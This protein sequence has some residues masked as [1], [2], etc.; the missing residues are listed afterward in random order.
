MNASQLIAKIGDPAFSATL[1]L[2]YG[3]D[4][5]VIEANRARYIAAVNRFVEIYGDRPC[6]RLFSTPG[7]TEIGGNHTDHNNGCV[8]AASVDLDTIAVAAANDRGVVTVQSEGFNMNSLSLDLLAPVERERLHSN[9]LIRGVAARM[10]Q[11]GMNI[12][13]FDAYTTSKVLKGSGLSSSAAFEV[14]VVSLFDH[15][16]NN[17]D[18]DPLK[19]AQI[20][21]YAENRFFGKPCGLMDQTACAYGGFVA[22]DFG[23]LNDPKATPIAFDFAHS[24]YSLVITDTRG[25]H[26]DLNDAYAAIRTEMQSVAGHYGKSVLRECSKEDVLRDAPS[27]RREAGDRAVLRALH[28]FDDNERVAR[29]RAALEAGDMPAFLA[30]VNASGRSSWMLLQNCYVPNGEQGVTL[31]LAVSAEMLDGRGAWRVHGGGFAGTIQAFVPADLTDA[32]CAAMDALFGDGSAHK[33]MIRPKG[34]IEITF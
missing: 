10:D 32:Y 34:A 16:Y 3:D 17:G 23:D 29:Q 26:S 33:L 19:A 18:I 4:S 1:A 20:A 8:L 31:G 21:Q 6:L 25:N 14:L 12:G 30:L 15:L 27:L 11:L 28:F 22:I 5:A 13:G 24:G 9:S 2:L 7:R